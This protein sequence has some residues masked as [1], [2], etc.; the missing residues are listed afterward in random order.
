MEAV[1]QFEFIIDGPEGDP[2]KQFGTLKMAP[3]EWR[4]MDPAAVLAD[5]MQ[6][7]EAQLMPAMPLRE[8]ADPAT[9]PQ[10]ETSPARP[11]ARGRSSS[12]GKGRAA[13]SP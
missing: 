8:L 10:P 5:A 3:R 13:P 11:R 7:I 4:A 6:Q 12:R 1:I 9:A 2:I